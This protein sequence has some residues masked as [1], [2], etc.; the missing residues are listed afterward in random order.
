VEG[1]IVWGGFSR[2]DSERFGEIEV[3]ALESVTP[4][5]DGQP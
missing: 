2:L 4:P 3:V 1:G 5:Q